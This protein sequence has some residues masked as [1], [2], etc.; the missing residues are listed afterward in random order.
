MKNTL[1]SF[2]KKVKGSVRNLYNSYTAPSKNSNKI[3]YHNFSIN[4][5]LR[6]YYSTSMS[7]FVPKFSIFEKN[8]G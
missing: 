7:S 6:R 1:Q 4:E 2:I 3:H 5:N 8:K